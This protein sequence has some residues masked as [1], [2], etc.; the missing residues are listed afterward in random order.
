GGMIESYWYENSH[1]Y[2]LNEDGSYDFDHRHHYRP[3]SN[4]VYSIPL[5]NGRYRAAT[6]AVSDNDL[7]VW[8]QVDLPAQQ[9]HLWIQNKNHTWANVVSGLDIPSVS[10]TVALF[11]LR[12]NQTYWVQ[13]WDTYESDPDRQ[14]VAIESKVARGDGSIEL[15]V[16]DLATDTAVK[17]LPL[18]EPEPIF[19]PITMAD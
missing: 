14:V 12:P 4:F 11:G 9:A 6:T 7:R 17:I 1:I 16:S 13:W 18:V 19:L 15:V 3:Y 8:G 5:H 10:G 2:S